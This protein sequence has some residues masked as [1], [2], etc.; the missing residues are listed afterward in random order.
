V[1][2]DDGAEQ[3]QFQGAGR[4]EQEAAEMVCQNKANCVAS[5][6]PAIRRRDAFD[7]G[8]IT[9]N[10]ANLRGCPAQDR[11]VPRGLLTRIGESVAQT[12]PICRRPGMKLTAAMKR[13]YEKRIRI[14]RLRK[15]SQSAR[16]GYFRRF[17]TIGRVALPAIPGTDSE[18]P[19]QTKPISGG[20]MHARAVG[21][22][23]QGFGPAVTGLVVGHCRREWKHVCC[24]R[25]TAPCG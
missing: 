7:T 22:G 5:I 19:R 16:R 6:L 20:R 25:M 2:A 1:R 9:P 4:K 15:Q 13:T 3:S 8:P 10:K 12:K 18:V 11:Q 17:C 23:I 24:H 14:V 21:Y